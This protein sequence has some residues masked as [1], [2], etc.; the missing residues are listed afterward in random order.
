[1]LTPPLL[2]TPLSTPRASSTKDRIAR[3]DAPVQ[4]QLNAI[5]STL[6]DTVHLGEA[7]LTEFAQQTETLEAAHTKTT[8]IVHEAHE[9][10]HVVRAM[11]STPYAMW[12][13]CVGLW[14]WL[15]GWLTVAKKADREPT[16]AGMHAT[17][18]NTLLPKSVAIED[19]DATHATPLLPSHVEY[20]LHTLHA[21]ANALGEALDKHLYLLDQLDAGVAKGNMALEAVP[22]GPSV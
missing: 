3:A 6:A 16:T 9:A 22:F 15:A 10:L 14:T 11:R 20:Q 5:E 8:A 19:T 7:M 13:W 1:M 2:T 12:R 18:G 21:Q 17:S 4:R